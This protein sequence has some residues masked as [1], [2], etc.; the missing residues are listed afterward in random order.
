MLACSLLNLII[1]PPDPVNNVG[2]FPLFSDHIPSPD[3][4]DNVGV[5]PLL[6]NYKTIEYIELEERVLDILRE[7]GGV[8]IEKGKRVVEGGGI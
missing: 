3:P 5:F 8:K 7:R 1:T 6:S 4:V 2:V